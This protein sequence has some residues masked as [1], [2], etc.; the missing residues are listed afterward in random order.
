M[1]AVMAGADV[2]APRQ[3]VQVAAS[4]IVKARK[5]G[6]MFFVRTLIR[7]ALLVA[8]GLAA[9]LSAA[10]QP[11]PSRP[12]KVIVPYP[13]GGNADL[14]ARLYSDAISGVFG[15]PVVIDNRPGAGGALGAEA[16]ARAAPD[17][18][19]V[20][21]ATNSELGVIPAIRGD[22]PYDP[23]KDLIAISTTSRFPFM[24]VVRKG[25]PVNNLQEL[26]ALAK[27]R[28]VTFASI[29]T[30]TANHLIIEPLKARFGID[31]PIVP[32]RGAGPTLTDLL[33]GHV[34]ANFATVSSMLQQVRAGDL[35]AILVTSKE[36]YPQLPDV[37]SAG[38]LGLPE[39]LTENWT[40]FLVPTG[41]D[42]EIV[43]K[44]HDVITR[45]GKSP[46]VVDAV[47]KAGSVAVTSASP[48]EVQ[49]TMKADIEHW[50]GIVKTY[51]I[52]L[53]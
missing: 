1:A 8:V 35:R 33:G 29:G 20:G 9:P 34:D 14:V 13:P 12:I 50:R 46:A 38:E 15:V 25:L 32:Y 28:P 17:G 23:P 19:T 41:T 37:P 47:Q 5:G 2:G 21:H 44:W 3:K 48:E 52:K 16:I 10:A 26:V 22:L 11:Y 42:R 31:L 49:A 6:S 24:I 27:Q 45:V 53:N 30:G 36:R 43:M 51:N 7:V 4:D 40:G 39:L 18:Y